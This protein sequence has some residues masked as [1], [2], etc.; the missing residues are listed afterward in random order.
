MLWRREFSGD[1]DWRDGG[2]WGGGGGWEVGLVVSASLQLPS[3]CFPPLQRCGRRSPATPPPPP[4]SGMQTGE[5]KSNESHPER[6]HKGHGDA[7]LQQENPLSSVVFFGEVQRP[8]AAKAQA[9]AL[10]VKAVHLSVLTL[11]Q[12]LDPLRALLLQR[13]QLLFNL[14]GRRKKTKQNV[15]ALS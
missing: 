8:Q 9:A 3:L 13:R 6:M 1:K 5:R 15:S 2:G 11:K 12:V 14:S 7:V 10:R 4:H